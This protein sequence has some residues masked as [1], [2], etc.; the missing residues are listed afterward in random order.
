MN[1]STTRE[2]EVFSNFFSKGEN[3]QKLSK[4]KSTLLEG[5]SFDSERK[6]LV[7]QR[8]PQL[9]LRRDKLLSDNSLINAIILAKLHSSTDI[10]SFIKEVRYY[11]NKDDLNTGF[12]E[13]MEIFRNRIIFI[14]EVMGS[15]KINDIVNKIPEKEIRYLFCNVIDENR[16]LIL[17]NP[18]AVFAKIDMDGDDY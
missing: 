13:V 15:N 18:L 2:D 14:K 10:D 11:A 5:P 12:L 17:E 8:I 16:D 9:Q 3:A 7:T 1:N 4:D 6:L